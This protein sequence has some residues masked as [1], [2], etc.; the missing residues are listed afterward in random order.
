[1]FWKTL[2]RA[3]S[4]LEVWSKRRDFLQG[5]L[6]YVNTDALTR[7]LRNNVDVVSALLRQSYSFPHS[8]PYWVM[9]IFLC[10]CL[11][12]IVWFRFML[13][14]ANL[15]KQFG[16][17]CFGQSNESELPNGPI[18]CSCLKWV[19]Y[20]PLSFYFDNLNHSVYSSWLILPVD[21][22]PEFRPLF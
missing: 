12:A 8:M 16:L 17:K 14:K 18:S 7:I 9:W 10:A 22:W 3:L 15:T 11:E 6:A 19:E 5:K 2:S 1:M 4:A 21:S 13:L 20:L